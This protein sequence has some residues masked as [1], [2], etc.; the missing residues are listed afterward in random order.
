MATIVIKTRIIKIGKHENL[1]HAG[2]NHHEFIFRE[3]DFGY[4]KGLG[5]NIISLTSWLYNEDPLMHL[6]FEKTFTNIKQKAYS[7]FFE[8]LINEYF[9]KNK[10]KTL[11]ILNP[12]KNL[13]KEKELIL[14]KKLSDIKNNLSDSEIE[15]ITKKNIE[16]KK[17]QSIKDDAYH[18]NTIPCLSLDDI[19][20]DAEHLL[21]E[22]IIEQNVKILYH[23]VFTNGIAYLNLFFNVKVIK[24]EKIQYISLLTEI[25][26]KINTK[27]QSYSNLSNMI[28]IYT[29]GIEFYNEIFISKDDDNQYNP[30]LVVESKAL[31]QNIPVL[32]DL[33]IEIINDSI[34]NNKKRM[35]ELIS[36]AISSIEISMMSQGSSYA[37]K[38]LYSY[39]SQ[40][41]MYDEITD[42]ISYYE[43][44]K[45]V[46]SMLDKD[47]NSLCEILSD[48]AKKIFN[49][50]NFLISITIDKN[51]YI[52]FQNKIS[53]L[54][55]SFPDNKQR[56]YEYNFK[57]EKL[58]EGILS[59]SL[60]QY[61][62][63]G[64]NYKKFGFNYS[65]KLQVLRTIIGL[66]YLWNKI[67]VLGG[68]YGSFIEFERNGR[69][70][71]GS[72]RDPNLKE[73]ID[74]F[75]N[76]YKYLK[77]LNLSEKEIIKYIIGTI[78]RYDRDLTPKQKGERSTD[79]YL[80]GITYDF[81]QHER[82][83]ILNTKFID[84][85]NMIELF[86]KINE[87]NFICV[88]GN[89]NK[90]QKENDLFL[91]LKKIFD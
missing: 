38:R 59:S 73:T 11:L 63:K 67:R 29:G 43:F 56:I 37:K 17:Y 39:Y 12:K 2:I 91:N 15:E 81:L 1:I 6:K 64:N 83:E 47:F 66:D 25:L 7:N 36:E 41:G 23:P 57:T 28:N 22:E 79:L 50:N 8:N 5:Y 78:K 75:T 54:L 27:K 86:K 35:K 72:Y 9:L 89:E 13:L 74:A 48:I 20:K 76:I 65:G 24:Q 53:T 18:K 90:I 87:E 44:I 70:N 3:A 52:N 31:I 45:K 26:G 80:S 55:N 61:V 32:I 82:E 68:A 71:I 21:L 34:F 10:Q 88:F 30:Y 42:G 14:N 49:K 4:P 77:N 60:V 46:E 16:L 84:I 19:K 69:F 33:I 51:D 40:A 62:V 58:N 85:K